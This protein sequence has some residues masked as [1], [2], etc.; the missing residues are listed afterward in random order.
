MRVFE[1][2]PKFGVVVLKSPIIPNR[3]YGPGKP[4]RVWTM[5]LPSIS[6]HICWDRKSVSKEI[7]HSLKSTLSA[8]ADAP[9]KEEL[10]GLGVTEAA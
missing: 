6:K 5:I 7:M 3:Y 2:E 9:L 8:Y 1:A 4:S 10:K